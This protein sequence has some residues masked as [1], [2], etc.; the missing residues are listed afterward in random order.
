MLEAIKLKKKPHFSTNVTR[1]SKRRYHIKVRPYY[2]HHLAV[3]IIFPQLPHASQVKRE[4]SFQ[5]QNRF[6]QHWKVFL[7]GFAQSL[8]KS[9]PLTR[10]TP[11]AHV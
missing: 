9:A 2:D 4:G 10:N 7:Y 3:T 5:R 11:E 8:S 1:D 6:P